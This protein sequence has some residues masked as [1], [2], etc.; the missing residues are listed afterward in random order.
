[1][2][3]ATIKLI[4]TI[5]VI[6]GGALLASASAASLTWTGGA[7]D[8]LFSSGENWSSGTAPVN[9]DILIFSGTNGAEPLT[10]T[11]DLGGLSVNTILYNA[12]ADHTPYR[13][14]GSD[15]SMPNWGVIRNLDTATQTITPSIDLAGSMTFENG[16]NTYGSITVGGTL[17]ATGGQRMMNNMIGG[18][19]T[20]GTVVV[21]GG[22]LNF[23]LAGG[24]YSDTQPIFTGAPHSKTIINSLNV[25]GAFGNAYGGGVYYGEI[26]F[27]GSNNIGNISLTNGNLVL[28]YTD[29]AD[30]KLSTGG[31]GFVD[32]GKLT[33]VGGA[34]QDVVGSLSFGH[35]APAIGGGNTVIERASGSSTI[36]VE[37]SIMRA[38]FNAPLAG[39]VNTTLSISEGGIIYTANTNNGTGYANDNFN[40]IIRPWVTVGGEGSTGRDWAFKGT[41][42]YIKAFDDYNATV[43]E[44]V[45]VLFIGGNV[46]EES[47]TI[48]S[49][50]LD[51]LASDPNNNL[52]NLDDYTLT[53]KSGGLLYVGAQNYT[54]GSGT[55]RMGQ[56]NTDE[57]LVWQSGLGELTVNADIIARSITKVGHG[58]LTLNG[59]FNPQ[60]IASATTG[61]I[62]LSEGVLK[63]GDNWS[64]STDHMW[65]L[66]Y[67]GTLNLNGRDLQVMSVGGDGVAP[68][69]AAI[70]ND[71]DA[72]STLTVTPHDGAAIAVAGLTST[73][74][75]GNVKLVLNGLDS[76]NA[77]NL[78]VYHANTHTGGVELSNFN[79]YTLTVYN[80]E[81]FGSGTVSLAGNAGFAVGSN[82]SGT[83]DFTNALRVTGSNN[84]V[85]NRFYKPLNFNN[86]WSGDGEL[87]V[88]NTYQTVNINAELSGF[89]GTVHLRAGA[90]P[91]NGTTDIATFSSTNAVA[92]WSTAA[93]VLDKANTTTY[94]R[95]FL[96][97]T[98]VGQTFKL[99][100]LS[101]ADNAA[102]GAVGNQYILRNNFDAGVVTFEIGAANQNGVFDGH[103]SNYGNVNGSKT[104]GFSYYDS[105]TVS[106]VSALTKVGSGTLTLT[107]L[108]TYTGTTTVS[109]G[110]LL[111]SGS[112]ALTRTVGVT[113]SDGGAFVYDST[114]AL[115]RA[116]NVSEGGIFGG[117]GTIS[118]AL[119]TLEAGAG[120]TGGGVL[121]TG[122]LTVSDALTLSDL[123]Y[124]WDIAADG[125]YDLLD[126]TD[127]LTLSG[128]NIVHVNAINGLGVLSDF[129]NVTILSGLQG[130]GL[131]L[132]SL[133]QEATD[134][135]FMLDFKGTS[136][137]LNYSAIP[138]PSTWAL[139]VTGVALLAVLRARKFSPRRH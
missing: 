132:W 69:P 75:A 97:N 23:L 63:L 76:A 53:V 82:V 84:L 121:S 93:V 110:V 64:A 48:N 131:E 38:G 8:G 50:K 111:V 98:L 127:G 27:T 35:Y 12:G 104:A 118:G 129:E 112:G 10:L 34:A 66:L 9:N 52:L 30:R 44:N 79:A 83:L 1:M 89:T 42:N 62:S 122:T 77:F 74:L 67:S 87:I 54:I 120:L 46:T 15:F 100:N 117:S 20:L 14:I 130:G 107:N 7:E 133:N 33:L 16:T 96:Q 24:G 108:H 37:G 124:Q 134:A 137:L 68:Q 29:S 125:D 41:N 92:D 39:L 70:I 65:L 36:K 78:I 116:V 101:S 91:N 59:A 113:V 80:L 45:N 47:A 21:N 31:L 119:L 102:D 128:G 105:H 3:I 81:W 17:T 85:S 13:I 114:V 135:G 123:I 19:L 72:M 32:G 86:T 115:D 99:G 57:F 28:D 25:A 90:D 40:G 139:M 5:L 2:K 61:M 126:F 58:T 22:N 49:L 51:S 109:G 18:T 73:K 95:N 106:R 4:G 55:L 26:R 138:E 11:N 60:A 136:L 103:I 43:D 88:E 94:A 6:A 56:D 71:S